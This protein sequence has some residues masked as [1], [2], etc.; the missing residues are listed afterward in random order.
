MV[1]SATFERSRYLSFG[2]KC[3]TP[4]HRWQVDPLHVR[5]N[6][7]QNRPGVTIGGIQTA[8]L[9]RYNKILLDNVNFET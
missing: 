3:V 6:Y 8:L 2:A 4:G 7:E 5:L 9:L 1:E